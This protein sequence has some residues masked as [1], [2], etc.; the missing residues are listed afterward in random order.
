MHCGHPIF[1][2][3]KVSLKMLINACNFLGNFSL[4][5]HN[6]ENVYIPYFYANVGIPGKD[7]KLYYFIVI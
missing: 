7:T 3:W 6:C 4:V 1:V 5:E 2:D